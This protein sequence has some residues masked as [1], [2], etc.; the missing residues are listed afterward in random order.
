LPVP[1]TTSLLGD[2]AY[3]DEPN[4]ETMSLSSAP[5]SLLQLTLFFG[6]VAE[7]TSSPILNAIAGVL[8]ETEILSWPSKAM[9][10]LNISGALLDGVSKVSLSKATSAWI[11][12]RGR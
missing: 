12:V 6:L 11:C 5:T 3:F 10:C 2:L 4:A 8:P 9:L 7:L 1:K